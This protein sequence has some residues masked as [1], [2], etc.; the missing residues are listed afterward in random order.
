MKHAA[1]ATT[2]AGAPAC[3]I[4]CIARAALVLLIGALAGCA[5]SPPT[6]FYTLEAVPSTSPHP[7]AS[8][9]SAPPLR[10]D[11]VHLPGVLNRPEI[12]LRKGPNVLQVDDFARWAAPLGE[13][14]QRVLTQDL[15][16]RLPPGHVV[17]PDAPQSAVVALTVEVLAFDI[18]DGRASLSVAWYAGPNSRSLQLE[19]PVRG[20]GPTDSAKALGA[21]LAQLADDV[22]AQVAS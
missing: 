22:A 5:Q 11:A 3:G 10:V 4:G 20:E 6:V 18:R 7:A 9:A 15:I 19:V 13:M 14:I 21:L 16:D 8:N 1:I 2:S 12:F 17:Y